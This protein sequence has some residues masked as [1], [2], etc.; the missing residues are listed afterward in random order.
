MA[1]PIDLR[2]DRHTPFVNTIAFVDFNFTGA[3]FKME[4]RLNKEA[5]GAALATLNTVSTEVQGVRLAFGGSDTVANHI[6]NGWLAGV[7]SGLTMASVVYV[8]VVKIR[9]DKTTV[10]AFPQSNPPGTDVDLA[11]DLHITPS[12]GDE[13]VYVAGKFTVVAGSTV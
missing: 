1:A 11:Y 2:A 5:T 6:A 8:S 7:P 10:V 9:I 4:V 12:G 13:Q 3:T